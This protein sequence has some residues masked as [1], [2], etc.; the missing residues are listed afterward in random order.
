M[1]ICIGTLGGRVGSSMIMGLLKLSG[2]D[3]GKVSTEVSPMNAK[4][5]FEI[6]EVNE[7]YREKFKHLGFA[8]FQPPVPNESIF[9]YAY[10]L[11]NKT[12][13]K[14]YFTQE[15][16]AIKAPYVFTSIMYN[17]DKLI[18]LKRDI[19]NQ[20]QSQQKYN[21]RKGDFEQWLKEW[22]AFMDKN[23]C[24]DHHQIIFEDFQKNPY[25][26]YIKMIKYIGVGKQ[27]TKK[28]VMDWFDPSLI[29]FK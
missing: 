17:F 3:V 11:R 18:W 6:D 26:E 12:P 16:I 7:W 28:Q 5:T 23:I 2:I 19:K 4:G 20:A 27:L 25:G 8:D 10:S 24:E 9:G 1:N 29:N 21:I 22:Y 13:Y 14:K 15:H